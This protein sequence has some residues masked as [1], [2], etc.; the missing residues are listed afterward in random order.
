MYIS[1][2]SSDLAFISGVLSKF[3]H[4]LYDEVVITEKAFMTWLGVDNPVTKEGKAS[5]LQ[6]TAEFFNW[7]LD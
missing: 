7:L 3:F 5:A 4:T 2:Y 1:N 6:E